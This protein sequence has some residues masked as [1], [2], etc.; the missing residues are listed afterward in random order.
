VRNLNSGEHLD[1]E[2][3]YSLLTAS[4]LLLWSPRDIHSFETSTMAQ[5]G[6]YRFLAIA[7]V[8]HLIYIYRSAFKIP[9]NALVLISA[10]SSQFIS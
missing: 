4:S 5:L 1:G 6:R 10:A 8:F 7:V 2:D 9:S 3:G